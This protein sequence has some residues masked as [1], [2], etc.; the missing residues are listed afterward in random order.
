MIRDEKTIH[1]RHLPDYFRNIQKSQD[2]PTEMPEPDSFPEK[3]LGRIRQSAIAALASQS[4][5]MAEKE[6]EIICRTLEENKGNVSRSARSIGISRQLLH[7]KIKK[8]QPKN[9]FRSA[10]IKRSGFLL[11]SVQK[12]P[13]KIASLNFC[14]P[15]KSKKI[16]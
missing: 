9:G 10:K 2:V 3:A 5:E 8:S 12:E 14:T 1:V 16:A 4:E 6:K 7:Y 11:S 15:E 13:Q